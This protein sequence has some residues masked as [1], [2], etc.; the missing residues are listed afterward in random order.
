MAVERSSKSVVEK[1]RY[2]IKGFQFSA[3]EAAIKKPGRLDLA[4][5]FADKPAQAVGVFTSNRVKAAPVIISQN[6]LRGGT[7]QA[8]LVNSGNANACTGESGLKDAARSAE[9]LAGHLGL[10]GSAVLVASTGVIGQPLPME[11]MEKS[12]PGLVRG[13]SPDRL[14]DVSRAILTTDKVPKVAYRRGKVGGAGISLLAVAKGAGMIMPNMATMLCFVMTDADISARA[15][16]KSLRNAVSFSFNRITVDGDMS[17]NDSVYLMAGGAAGNRP[18]TLETEKERFFF[19]SL[20]TDLL[21]EL[22]K[23]IVRDG[24]GAKK[25]VEIKVTGASAGNEA[26]KVAYAVANSPLVKTAFNGEDANWGRIMAAIGRSGVS[27]RPEQIRISFDSVSL[28]ENGLGC[29]LS[30]EQAA[31]EIMRKDEFALLIDLGRGNSGYNVWTCDFSKEYIEIN[32][33]YRT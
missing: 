32:G 33:S 30:A 11:K 20:L 3:V 5:I 8:I 16:K 10:D 24:E 15:L 19:E 22:A 18:V 26:K 14:P 23:A 7:A 12:L 21:T 9:K 29:G 28:V 1:N 13:L 17:T 31:T 4:L 6:H 25:L 27:I 2:Y